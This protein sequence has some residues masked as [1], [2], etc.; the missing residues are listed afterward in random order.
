MILDFANRSGINFNRELKF[1]DDATASLPTQN[2]LFLGQPEIGVISDCGKND[3]NCGLNSIPEKLELPEEIQAPDTLQIAEELD[4]HSQFVADDTDAANLGLD[5]F[6]PNKTLEEL[7][8]INMTIEPRETTTEKM[9]EI[10]MLPRNNCNME[11][12]VNELEDRKLRI[13]FGPLE[14][15]AVGQ[16]QITLNGDEK[17][18]LAVL[19]TEVK[20]YRTG[21]DEKNCLGDETLRVVIANT[22]INFTMK[23]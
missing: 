8:N 17:S 2:D 21:N 1:K 11:I 15:G 18:M 20:L 12:H 16:C 13:Y 4:S 22:G 3:S 23:Q 7:Q 14:N 9:D 6:H 19:L 10:I 5:H